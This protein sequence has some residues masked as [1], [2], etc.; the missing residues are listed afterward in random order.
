M[1]AKEEFEIKELR[2][3]LSVA[4]EPIYKEDKRFTA[5]KRVIGYEDYVSFSGDIL[6]IDDNDFLRLSTLVCHEKYGVFMVI[7]KD[8][9]IKTCRTVKACNKINDLSIEKM[10]VYFYGSPCIGE[11]TNNYIRYGK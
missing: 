9:N 7:S 8:L 3:R 1:E 2:L 6:I 4:Q 5:G 10:K 11:A